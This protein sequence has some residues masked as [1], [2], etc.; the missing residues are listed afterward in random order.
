MAQAIT[1]T[2]KTQLDPASGR[3]LQSSPSHQRLHG[4]EGPALLQHVAGRSGAAAVADAHVHTHAALGPKLQTAG[5]GKA[6]M[7]RAI[8]DGLGGGGTAK[9]LKGIIPPKLNVDGQAYVDVRG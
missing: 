4:R 3:D 7:Q 6:G 2:N 1:P 9:G 8:T 5:R